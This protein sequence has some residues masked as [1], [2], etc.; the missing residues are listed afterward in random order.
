MAMLK[1]AMRAL[2]GRGRQLDSRLD[3]NIERSARIGMSGTAD[4]GLYAALGAAIGLAIAVFEWIS[5]EFLLHWVLDAPLLV[6]AVLPIVGLTLATLIIGAVNGA[7]TSTS[8]SYLRAFHSRDPLPVSD[9]PA[10]LS[11]SVAT[12]SSGAALGLEG[13]AVFLGATFGDAM[14]SRLER[15]RGMSHRALLAAGAAAGVAAVFKA[16]ATGVLFALESPFRRDLARHALIPS[17]VASSASYL[18]FVLIL[19]QDRL[20]RIGPADLVLRHEVGGAILLGLLGGFTARWTSV[21]F[22]RA[23]KLPSS[24]TATKRLPIIGLVLAGCLLAAN[25]LVG[26]PATLGPGAEMAVE[27]VLDADLSIWVIIALFGLRVIATSAALAGGGV[28]GVFIPLV[29]QGLLLGSIVERV[30]DA[31]ANGLYPVIG[32]AA[33]LGA[34][35]RTPLAAVTFV[36]ETTGRA[37]FVIPALLAVAISQACMGDKSVSSGQLDERKGRL[38]RRLGRPASDVTISNISALSPHDLL[39]DVIDSLDGDLRTPAIPVI[40][41][42]DCKL[43]VLN[44]IA[45]AIFERGDEAS[46]KDVMRSIPSVKSSSPAM[47]A[48]RIMSTYNCAAIAVVDDDAF[49]IGI[50]T[51]ESLAGLSDIDELE[52]EG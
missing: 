6:Q 32:L 33:V 26:L 39:V 2:I 7:T 18:V 50:V 12:L 30:L 3:P 9:L 13:P 52:D 8:D 43:L 10:S 29:V 40:D 34:G 36:A 17:L 20:L 14:A 4:F 31:P 44:D 51:A 27:V 15:F 1:D 49:P 16:P 28:G 5:I 37:E 41:G 21:V 24:L 47:E 25:A 45:S 23:K 35:Y 38:E 42:D 22:Q 46:V 11:A 48:A 19:G